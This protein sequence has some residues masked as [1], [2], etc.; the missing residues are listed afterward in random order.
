MERFNLIDLI[1]GFIGNRI[2]RFIRRPDIDMINSK[3]F[4]GGDTEVDTEEYEVIDLTKCISEGEYVDP[5]IID[6]I[7]KDVQYTIVNN[8]KVFIH[9]R[10]GRSRAPMIAMAWL[11]KYRNFN[12]NEAIF[13]VRR[14]RPYVYL[15]WNQIHCLIDYSH[16]VGNVK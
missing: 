9:C 14:C 5:L 7:V 8:N 16:F 15:N 3:L 11:I 6:Y 10:V 1:L 2:R 13:L 12:M 4:V